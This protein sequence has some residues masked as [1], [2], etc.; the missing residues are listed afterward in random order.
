[1][2][3]LCTLAGTNVNEVFPVTVGEGMIV[4]EMKE[5]IQRVMA[6]TLATI[7][8]SRSPYG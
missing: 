6:R 8:W 4:G 3:L 1:M 5:E 7:D 2:R